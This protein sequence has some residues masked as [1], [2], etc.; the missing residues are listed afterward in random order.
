MLT[1][2]QFPGVGRLVA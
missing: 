2:T 1:Q